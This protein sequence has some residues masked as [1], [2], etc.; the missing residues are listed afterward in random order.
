MIERHPRLHFNLFNCV[1]RRK[2]ALLIAFGVEIVWDNQRNNEWILGRLSGTPADFVGADDTIT[3]Y[4][5]ERE[6]GIEIIEHLIITGSE[7]ICSAFEK[8]RNW[9]QL[10]FPAVRFHLTE[11][12]S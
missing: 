10:L 8:L 9:H 1:R 11:K 6:P 12:K 2:N 7:K 4:G 3:N 5:K